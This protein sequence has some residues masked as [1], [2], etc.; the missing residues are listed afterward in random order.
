LLAT[1]GARHYSSAIQTVQKWLKERRDE[2]LARARRLPEQL[3]GMTLYDGANAV[4][5]LLLVTV[6]SLWLRS[7]YHGNEPILLDP[8]LQPDD[9]RTA[10]FP[11]HRYSEGA[12]LADDPIANEMLEY[13]P[14]AYRLLFRITVPFVGLLMATKYVQALLILIVVAAGEV[15]SPA[16]RRGIAFLQ[17]QPREGARWAEDYWT[18]TGFPRVF[19][20]KYHGYSAYFPLM[21]LAR[22]RNLMRC[23]QQRVSHGM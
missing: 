10:I 19:Y 15:E 13:Q 18:G 9:A 3:R 12:P 1:F 21:A 22:Y 17:N 23:N 16:V 14:Y 2:L 4:T 7:W 8:N 5:A 6:A 11:F 20:L